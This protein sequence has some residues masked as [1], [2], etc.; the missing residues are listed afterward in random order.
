MM[1]AVNFPEGFEILPA[2]N[3]EDFKLI[4]QLAEEIIPA[5]Y[6]DH[7]DAAHLQ[8]F[9]HRFHA[10]EE[11]EKQIIA[12]NLYFIFSF[13]GMPAGYM[14]LYPHEDYLH[15]SKLYLLDRFRSSGLGKLI[16]NYIQQIAQL[17]PAC[18]RIELLVSIGNPRGIEFYLRNGFA[19]KEY[20]L[21]RYESGYAYEDFKMVKLLK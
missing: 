8:F 18:S 1:E 14:A 2:K 16:L 19:K 11:I 7:I 15:I 20:V 9:V 21:S 4:F 17:N 10:P 3:F 13:N 6:A 5:F 12:G